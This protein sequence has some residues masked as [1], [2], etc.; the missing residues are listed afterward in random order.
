MRRWTSGTLSATALLSTAFWLRTEDLPRRI[1]FV[2]LGL[3]AVIFWM[4]GPYHRYL[5]PVVPVLLMLVALRLR[6]LH[7]P[8]W[9]ASV[10]AIGV[11]LLQV[12]QVP[13]ALP[14]IL[15]GKAARETYLTQQLWLYPTLRWINQNTPKDA[16]ILS[17]P[18]TVYYCDRLCWLANPYLQGAIRLTRYEDFCADVQ[19][20]GITHIVVGH[21]EQP[22]SETFPTANP[23]RFCQ[24][25]ARERGTQVFQSSEMAVWQLQNK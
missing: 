20:A 18:D 7:L 3:L 23:V 17:I 4:V 10:A 1:G 8:L 25:L 2:T 22:P 24:R 14:A 15:G 11:G 9:L 19:R 21:A 16:R 12:R 13:A 6:S 5:L